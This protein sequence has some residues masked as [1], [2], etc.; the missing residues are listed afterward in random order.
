MASD[1]ELVGRLARGD[2]RALGH[3]L[4][5]WDR[6]LHAFIARHTGGQPV[7]N[8]EDLRQET[9]LRV[10]RAAGRFDPARRFTTWLFQIALNLC[11]D[12]ARRAAETPLAPDAAE[13]ALADGGGAPAG[14]N[15]V[16]FSPERAL[17]A[18]TLLA[19]LPEAQRSAMILRYYHGLSEEETAAVLDCPRG[20]VKSRLHQAVSK[21]LAMTQEIETG[22]EEDRR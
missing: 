13:R 2:P 7:Q 16:D 21:L 5:R 12:Q 3:L 20:T 8:V 1:E 19:R 10:V 4:E 11:R 14:G 22:V 9:W 17:D 18:R 6:P 15:G